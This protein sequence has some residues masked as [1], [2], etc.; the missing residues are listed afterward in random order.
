MEHELVPRHELLT[1]KEKQEILERFDVKE[2]DMPKI[3]SNDP[4]LASLSAMSGDLIKITRKSPTAGE[5]IYYRIVVQA[6]KTAAERAA[7]ARAAKAEEEKAKKEAEKLKKKAA[8]KIQKVEKA[9]AAHK[10]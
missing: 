9:V 7:E 5:S 4:A 8:K 6:K 2:R 1:K 3:F 10:K